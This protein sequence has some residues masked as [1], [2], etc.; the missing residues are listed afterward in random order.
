VFDSAWAVDEL[1]GR[2]LTDFVEVWKV[3]GTDS[4]VVFNGHCGSAG[5]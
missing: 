1:D 3:W 4:S 2:S 5:D